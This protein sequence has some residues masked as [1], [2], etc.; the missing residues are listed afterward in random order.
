M[1]NRNIYHW[2]KLSEN[3]FIT[4][5]ENSLGPKSIEFSYNNVEY[6]IRNFNTTKHVQHYELTKYTNCDSL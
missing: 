3:A 5:T 6:F 1:L 4:S 2:Q